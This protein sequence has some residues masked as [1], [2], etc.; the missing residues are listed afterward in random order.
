MTT[1]QRTGQALRPTH[2]PRVKR[3]GLDFQDAR[4]LVHVDGLQMGFRVHDY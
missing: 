4:H 2:Q 3:P 1:P